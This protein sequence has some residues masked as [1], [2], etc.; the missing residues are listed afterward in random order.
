MKPIVFTERRFRGLDQGRDGADLSEGYLV[1]ADNAVLDGDDIVTRPGKQGQLATALGSPIFGMTTVLDNDG[2]AAALFAS[3]GALYK[4][5]RGGTTASSLGLSGLASASVQI[6]LAAGLAWLVDGSGAIRRYNMADASATSLTELSKPTKPGATITSTGLLS[7]LGA[8]TWAQNYITG[9]TA[10][11]ATSGAGGTIA[12]RSSITPADSNFWDGSNLTGRPFWTKD[13][14]ATCSPNIL[15]ANGQNCIEL[16]SDTGTIEWGEST[17]IKLNPNVAAD[18]FARVFVVEYEAA[19]EDVTQTSEVVDLYVKGYSDLTAATVV[20][21]AERKRQ[22]P[23]L[24]PTISTR[25]RELIDWRGVRMAAG[26][27]LKSLKLRW[28]QPY[29]RNSSQGADVNRAAIY[30][31]RMELSYAPDS[32]GKLSVRQGSVQVWQ[33]A[34]S[35]LTST[36]ETAGQSDPANG[37]T[38]RL[39][40]GGLKLTT[41]LA[42]TQNFT[43]VRT[44]G[45]EVLPASGVT[46]LAL[47]VGFKV[48]STWYYSTQLDIPTGGGWAVGEISAVASSLNAVTDIS[49]EV[50]N[51]LLVE[52]LQEN[53]DAP[54]FRLGD[55]RNVGN[56]AEGRPV[57][58]TL[59]EVDEVEDTTLLNTIQSDGSK[60]SEQI[61]PDAGKRMGSVAIP[62]RVN[63]GAEWFALYRFGGTLLS[64]VADSANDS[65]PASVLPAQG[66]LVCMVR[67]DSAAIP[68]GSDADKG[69]S[70][71][72]VA[73]GNPY[74]SWTPSGG[75]GSG[76][77]IL[78]NTPDSWLESAPVYVPGRETAPTAPAAIASWDGR[79]WAAQGAELFASWLL[80]PNKPAGVYWSRISLP[81]SQDPEAARKGWWSLLALD[82][83]DSILSLVALENVLIVVCRRSVWAVRKSENI[84]DRVR[85]KPTRLEDEDATGAVGHAAACAMGKMCY[86]LAFDGLRRTDG[87]TVSRFGGELKRLIQPEVVEGA[88]ALSSTAMALCTLRSTPTRLY[89]TL[90]TDAGDSA[91]DSVLVWHE[92]EPGKGWT[93]WVSFTATGAGDIGGLTLLSARDGQLWAMQGQGDKSTPSASA[94]AVSMTISSRLFGDGYS[95]LIPQ[96]QWCELLAGGSGDITLTTRGDRGAGASSRI[97]PFESGNKNVRWRPSTSARGKHNQFVLSVSTV[98]RVRVRQFG[99]ET[100]VYKESDR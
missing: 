70:P 80:E 36:G 60:V 8:L 42:A 98:E 14:N 57:W 15:A 49:I 74:I 16:D 78:D 91:P 46:G 67:W 90:P 27:D 76:G 48:G 20:T 69:V 84:R 4:W 30:F 61:E 2:T 72:I 47:R 58:Y 94:T 51:D 39:L 19:G 89:L 66:R 45:L 1:Q 26:T 79:L 3:G 54:L 68:T 75:T 85:Y 81:D 62:A 24:S 7:G 92:D 40:A 17:A 44:I 83:A 64:G 100:S 63:S 88:A 29:I 37:Q 52:G 87:R 25:V 31:P 34:G 10:E 86:W 95:T 93:R 43:G 18:G 73:L 6:A 71:R 82:P 59:V 53:G 77:T 38:A 32:D 99:L 12:P 96:R 33:A 55:L 28:E 11:P 23:F 9:T 21:S 50:I 22:S 41:T 65:I 56:L 13:T 5:R 35:T 97:L